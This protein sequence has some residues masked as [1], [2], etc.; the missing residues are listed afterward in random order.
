MCFTIGQSLQPG[1]ICKVSIGGE[2]IPTVSSAIHLGTSVHSKKGSDGRKYIESRVGKAKRSFYP[3]LGL[4]R[5]GNTM[6]VGVGSKLYWDIV[7]NS[8]LFGVE[9]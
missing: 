4:V 9:V 1:N 6:N 3:M 2:E 8:M 5:S 7:I